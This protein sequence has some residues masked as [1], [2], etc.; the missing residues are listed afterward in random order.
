VSTAPSIPGWEWT[1]IQQLGQE[2]QLSGL[3]PLIIGGI[4][5]AESSGDPG[6]P[7]SSGYGGYFGLG[8]GKVYP[9]GSIPGADMG[10]NTPQEL[11]A[12]AVVAASAF[13]Q[14]LG[15]AG[16][17]PIAAEEIYQSGSASGPTEGSQILQG[18]LGG[19]PAGGGPVSAT[20]TSATT[21]GLNANPLDLF[22]IPGTVAGGAAS[23]T[24]GAVG[25]FLVKAI[26]VVTGLSIIALAAYKAASPAIKKTAQIAES[27]APLVAAA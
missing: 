9:G 19:Q 12:E 14:Y 26:L 18:L 5:Q 6:S 7:N 3:N 15:Q 2:G 4:D 25:P 1:E 13:N 8:A 10:T 16:G 11:A 27:A 24:W 20:N 17:D 21:A 23:A 22:G